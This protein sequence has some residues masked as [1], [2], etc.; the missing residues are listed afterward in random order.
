MITEVTNKPTR[1]LATKMVE[2]NELEAPDAVEHPAADA[3]PDLGVDDVPRDLPGVP[4][5]EDHEAR[6]LMVDIETLGSRP[7]AAIVSIGAVVFTAERVISEFECNVSSVAAQAEGLKFDAA[8]ILWWLRQSSAAVEATFTPRAMSTFDALTDLANYATDERVVDY[9]SH[10]ATFDLV[11]LNEASLITGAPQLVKDFRRARDTRTLYEITGVNPK[12]FMGT[13]TAH[14]AV[15]DA[16]A[17][18][19]AVIESWRILRRWKNA[20]SGQASSK[21]FSPWGVAS[22]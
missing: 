10:G 22:N 11:L 19:L 12:T 15:D 4:L 5:A 1:L 6:S 16:R 14:N 18:A 9:W 7:G 2:T 3:L 8:T 17:Q 13:G 21:L 20:A